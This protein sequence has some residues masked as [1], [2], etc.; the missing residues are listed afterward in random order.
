PPFPPPSCHRPSEM[1]RHPFSTRGVLICL[2]GT[3]IWST[4]AIFIA[5]LS[6]HYQLP[7]LVLAFWRDLFVAL[8]LAGGFAVFR[9]SLLRL[10][11]PRRDL[12]FFA[13]YGLTLAVFNGLWTTSVALNGAA[14][15]T[16]L[17]Y[18]SPA[19]TALAERA[20]FGER[21]GPVRVGALFL[22]LAGCV[23]VS[24]A[25]EPAAWRLNPLGILVG[26]TSGLAFTA[27]SLFG[28]A[29]HRRALSP[30]TATFGAFTTATAFLLLFQRPSTLFWLG[31]RLDGWAVLLLLALIPTIGGYGLYTV[32]LTYLPA[33]VANLIVTLE[34][35][36]TA[37]MAYLI[38]GER[39]TPAQWLGGGLILTGIILLEVERRTR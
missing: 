2:A 34:P 23:L 30:W 3:A 39:L 31:N 1:T 38:L 4:T 12:G 13:A 16:V 32:S 35:V 19:F 9:P 20:L 17:V 10:P 33:G 37:A 36:M 21:F 5:H 18:S 29:A 11:T 25:Y 15:A 26:L 6:N 8:G 14:V 27:Y 28:R 24:G 7:P 22:S